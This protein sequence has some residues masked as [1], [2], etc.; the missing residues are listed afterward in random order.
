[1]QDICS[2]AEENRYH[3]CWSH[4]MIV[5]FW[6]CVGVILYT[7][8]GYPLLLSLLAIGKKVKTPTVEEWP[9]L[10]VLIVAHNEEDNVLRKIRNVFENGYPDD[11]IEVIVCSDGSTDR[12][13][14]RVLSYGDSRVKL[15]ASPENIGVNEAFGL[16]AGVANGDVLLM[17]D[18][19][20]LFESEAIPKVACHFADPRVG[21]ATGRIE[22]RN[23]LG[24]AVGSGYRG[25]WFVETGVRVLESRIGLAAVIVGAF[26]MIRKELY[27]AVP[28]ELNNDMIAPMHVQ[29]QG[30]L[31]R[32]EPS[33]VQ[34][35]DQKKTPQQDFARRVRMAIRGWSSIPFLLKHVPF[36]KNL[37]SWCAIISHKYLRW[38]TWLFMAGALVANIVLFQTGLFWSVLLCSQLL[39]YLLAGMGFLLARMGKHGG[40]LA[41]PFYFCLLQAA[42]M[43][44]LVHTLRGKRMGVWKPV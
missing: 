34:H 22:Y 37:G 9:F 5:M 30:R 28:S 16:G 38:L 19:G 17:T 20:N 8:I 11:R 31:C 39:F 7:Y 13:N 44:G 23:P 29:S 43:L 25:Y 36:Y 27:L 1:M 21:I 32:F 6:V 15:A 33:A 10:S 12:T 18:A 42:G 24:T 14:E 35:T 40:P 4:N 2:L 3:G 41:M 26:E